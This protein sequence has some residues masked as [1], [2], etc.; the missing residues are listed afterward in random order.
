MELTNSEKII[1]F[2]NMYKITKR[3]VVQDDDMYFRY[4]CFK[5]IDYIK[6]IKLPSFTVN[7]YYESVLIEYRKFPHVEFLIRNTILKLGKKWSHTVVCGTQN[8][9]Y[10]KNLCRNISS[11]IKVIKT[12]HENLNNDPS[13]YNRFLTSL[14]FWKLFNGEKL[15][16]YKEDSVIFKNNINDFLNFDFIGA[17]FSK[18]K[19]DNITPNSVGDGGFSIRTKHIMV[20]IINFISINHTDFHAS[21]LQYIKNNKLTYAP[22]DVYFSK[23]M[24]DFNIGKVADWE[25]ANRFSTGLHVYNPE[26]FGGRK[27]WA[28]LKN[29]KIKSIIKKRINIINYDFKSDIQLYL[30]HTNRP[31]DLNNTLKIKNAFDVDLNFCNIVNNLGENDKGVLQFIQSVGLHGNIYHP[32]QVANLYPTAKFYT[33]LGH[34]FVEYKKKMYDASQFVHEEI[35][36]KG[37]DYFKDKLIREVFTHLNK[38]S[39]L[40]VL[41]FI[42]NQERG[43]EL[44][45]KLIDYKKIQNFNLAICFNSIEICKD[46]KQ[47]VQE[48]FEYYSV[49]LSYEFGTDITPTLLMYEHLASSVNFEFEHIIKLHTKSI[50]NVYS[51]LTD[52][53]LTNPLSYVLVNKNNM[54]NCICPEK[55][56]MN[57][58]DDKFNRKLIINSLDKID[59]RK[60]FVAGTIFYCRKIVFDKVIKFVRENNFKSYLLNNLYENNS[61]NVD[62]SPIH[63][64]ERLFGVIDVSA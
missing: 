30:K 26:S 41:L 15:L 42:G 12:N 27:F 50:T 1:E 58:K 52:F 44:V 13:G 46:L 43:K 19:N 9:E 62:F 45:M 64:L 4:A 40:M 18:S 39:K 33:V 54:C 17:S 29:E 31:L 3:E 36:N 57:L 35:Y 23:N 53:L 61:I 63:F 2:C 60:V 24:Q 51:E 8:H 14:D 47:L 7:N 56:Y 32:K 16:I 5:N 21:T 22:E 25:T 34:V 38:S 6:K 49:Y 55:Y 37:Y 20:K 10:M 28:S 11:N 59:E 48:N